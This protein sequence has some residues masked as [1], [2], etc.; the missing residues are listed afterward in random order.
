M[1]FKILAIMQANGCCVPRDARLNPAPFSTSSERPPR[2]RAI[3]LCRRS[4]I[5]RMTRGSPPDKPLVPDNG[6]RLA[7]NL[8]RTTSERYRQD[9]PQCR[10]VDADR[11]CSQWKLADQPNISLRPRPPRPQNPVKLR[12]AQAYFPRAFLKKAH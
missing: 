7:S 11:R 2:K 10:N 8:I 3:R 1:D 4:L 5:P 6:H 12:F 9:E